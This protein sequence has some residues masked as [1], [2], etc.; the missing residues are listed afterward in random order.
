MEVKLLNED[1]NGIG[2]LLAKGPTI[3][4]GYYK[5]EEAT[6]QAIDEDGWLHTGDLAHIDKDGYIFISGRKKDVIVLQ[7]GKNVF[8]EEIE[9]LVNKVEGVNESFIYGKPGNNGD[10]KIAVK[11]VYN[12][13]LMKHLYEMTDEEKIQKFFAEEVK[14]INQNM[15]R[16]KS[17]KEVSVSEEPLIK[18]T[19]LKIKR[20][21]ELKKILDEK[22]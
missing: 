2:E 12:K 15:P 4:L 5:N 18:T 19:T 16:Y 3:M 21:E 9:A 11:I 6:K 1:E 10:L 14:K 7:N 17:I 8:P 20:H 22:R 13:E